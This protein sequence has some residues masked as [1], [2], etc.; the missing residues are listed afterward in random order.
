MTESENE[1][2]TNFFL[3]FEQSGVVMA[4]VIQDIV[5]LSLLFRCLGTQ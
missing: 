2:L 1:R 3:N 5:F 4:T